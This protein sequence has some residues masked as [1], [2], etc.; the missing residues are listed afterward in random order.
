MGRCPLSMKKK[1]WQVW[2]LRP[3]C[4][5]LQYCMYESELYYMHS[6][7]TKRTSVMC[8]HQWREKSSTTCGAEKRLR[9]KSR[10]VPVCLI[11]KWKKNFWRGWGRSPELIGGGIHLWMRAFPSACHR[12][13]APIRWIG[14]PLQKRK[15]PSIFEGWKRL[16]QKSCPGPKYI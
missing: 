11:W 8:K 3:W 16:R 12:L 4:L 13:S 14:H 9:Q 6:Y 10:P 2:G 1:L 7:N 5:V 15:K